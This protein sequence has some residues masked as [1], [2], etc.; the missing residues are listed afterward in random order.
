MKI[1]GLL[2]VMSI[3]FCSVPA[4]TKIPK[5]SDY[6][7]SEVYKGKNAPVRIDSDSRLFKTRLRWAVR[8]Q[9]PNFAGRYI[10]TFWGCGTSCI[11]GAAIDAKTGTVYWW[12]FSTAS[13][14]AEEKVK[15]RLNSRLIIFHGLRNEEDGDNGDHYYQFNGRK[16]VHVKTV[17]FEDQ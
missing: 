13:I 7:V 10:L 1:F 16:F 3:C 2:I 8:N 5:F 6:S 15:Y 11:Q 14:D 4:Q 12:G 17:L 9:K